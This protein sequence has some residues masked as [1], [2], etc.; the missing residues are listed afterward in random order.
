MKNGEEW[1]VR[2]NTRTH[3]SRD[4]EGIG[5]AQHGSRSALGNAILEHLRY[6]LET[7]YI[8]S[9]LD[10]GMGY[11]ATVKSQRTT[12]GL[13]NLDVVFVVVTMFC[14]CLL[15]TS[16]S[17]RDKRQSRMPSSA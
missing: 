8:S 6:I 13:S 12:H 4:E 3:K 15:Y 17:P 7:V 2:Q 10:V 9:V 5:V 14:T 16:P 11:R 1:K